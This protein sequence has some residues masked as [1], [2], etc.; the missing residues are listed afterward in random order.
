MFKAGR[1][2]QRFQTIGNVFSNNIRFFKQGITE[3]CIKG[4]PCFFY[5]SG[6][7]DAGMGNLGEGKNIKRNC[8]CLDKNVN[9]SK[10]KRRNRQDM[11]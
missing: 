6:V 7:L 4:N 5:F 3:G 9:S 10:V 11:Q 2:V 1:G 8:I